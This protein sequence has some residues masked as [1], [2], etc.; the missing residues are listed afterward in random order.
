MY[1]YLPGKDM[2]FP[3]TVTEDFVNKHLTKKG[4]KVSEH[5]HSMYM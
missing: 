1:R 5:H 3:Y 4:D 2:A